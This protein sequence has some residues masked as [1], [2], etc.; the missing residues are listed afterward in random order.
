MTKEEIRQKI[1]ENYEII[2]TNLITETFTLNT[3][4]SELLEENEKLRQQCPHEFKNGTC[5]YCD[6]AEEEE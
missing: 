6:L 2:Q 3:T 4:I 1:N 5:I